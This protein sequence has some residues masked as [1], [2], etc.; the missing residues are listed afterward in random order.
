L[1]EKCTQG[2]R[3]RETR[4]PEK[5]EGDIV[6]EIA[7]GIENSREELEEFFGSSGL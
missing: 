5:T 2:L 6:E 1:H 3:Y 4:F 7:V